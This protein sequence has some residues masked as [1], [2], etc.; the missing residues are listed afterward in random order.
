MRHESFKPP[1]DNLYK[2]ELKL[3]RLKDIK[4][5]MERRVSKK[6]EKHQV[7]FKDAIKEWF[8]T[9]DVTLTRSAGGDARSDFLKFVYDYDG[10]SLTKEDFQKRKRVKNVV[11]HF[12]RCTAKRANG[13]QCTRRK[14][15]GCCF[16]GTH[17]KGTPHGVITSDGEASK[18]VVKI[19]VWVQ[20]IK[21]INYYIDS[22]KNVYRAEDIIGNRSAPK[23]IAKWAMDSGEYVI[24]AF[25]T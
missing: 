22:N 5:Q 25:N 20:E 13:D 1:G 2:I 9:N 15:D 14:K 10:L 7:A 3:Y 6:I 18:G 24:P 8:E 23:V 12:E 11:P 4:E 16:C 19:E 17:V 21:G